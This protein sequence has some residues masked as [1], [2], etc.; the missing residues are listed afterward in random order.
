MFQRGSTHGFADP[1]APSPVGCTLEILQLPVM[2]DGITAWTPLTE[3]TGTPCPRRVD[4]VGYLLPFWIEVLDNFCT[5]HYYILF[6]AKARFFQNR[7]LTH[8]WKYRAENI[9]SLFFM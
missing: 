1:A 8:P 9:F 2:R 6:P 5:P 4:L 7:A 3:V